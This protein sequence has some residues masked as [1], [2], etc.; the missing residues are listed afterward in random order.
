MSH[1]GMYEMY[2]ND[3]NMRQ[4]GRTVWQPRASDPELEAEMLK[5]LQIKFAGD[6]SVQTTSAQGKPVKTTYEPRAVVSKGTNGTPVLAAQR[7]FRS[8]VA[9]RWIVAGSSWF[10]G[11]GRDRSG[12]L[13]YVRISEPGGE[14]KKP[15]SGPP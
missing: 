3:A 14:A 12:G 13:Y 10:S 11:A 15:V 9:A 2:V 8:R 6:Q 4:T 7:R 1:R 5:R